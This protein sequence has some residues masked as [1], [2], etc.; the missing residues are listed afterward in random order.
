M[1]EISTQHKEWIDQ[2]LTKVETTSAPQK[3][4][5]SSYTHASFDQASRIITGDIL[6]KEFMQQA[7]AFSC[8]PAPLVWELQPPGDL[9]SISLQLPSKHQIAKGSI[10]TKLSTSCW[11]NIVDPTNKAKM[12]DK[13]L[14][15]SKW[16]NLEGQAN[17]QLKSDYPTLVVNKVLDNI[18]RLKQLYETVLVTDTKERASSLSETLYIK[19]VT[20]IF[21]MDIASL[22]PERDSY[23]G[24]GFSTQVCN[25]VVESINDGS[26]FKLTQRVGLLDQP[27]LIGGEYMKPIAIVIEKDAKTIK[28]KNIDAMSGQVSEYGKTLEIREITDLLSQKQVRPIGPMLDL[29]LLQLEDQLVLHHGSEYGSPQKVQILCP[30]VVKTQYHQIFPDKKDSFAPVKFITSDPDSKVYP[31]LVSLFVWNIEQDFWKDKL[32]NSLKTGA[33]QAVNLYKEFGNDC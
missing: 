31:S 33:S 24:S 6:W 5:Y 20:E 25:K 4:A 11:W 16:S 1:L 14:D 12:A 18:Q 30:E 23:F 13:V 29:F 9:N 32:I 8:Q 10:K 21:G 28:S 27:V 17:K 26:I 22:L 7:T 3:I 19:M 2:A 15:P